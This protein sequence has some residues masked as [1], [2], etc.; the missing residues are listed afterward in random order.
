MT[1]LIEEA[2]YKQTLFI[3]RNAVPTI[4]SWSASAG[5]DRTKMTMENWHEGDLFLA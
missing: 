2:I 1:V 4:K 3:K 5:S